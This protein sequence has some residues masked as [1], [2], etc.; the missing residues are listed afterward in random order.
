MTID[1]RKQ[2][3]FILKDFLRSMVLQI[4]QDQPCKD[5]SLVSVPDA[6]AGAFM[7]VELPD[8]VVYAKSAPPPRCP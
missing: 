6:T 3:L 1:Q 7:Q 8:I 5:A 4:A 2:H